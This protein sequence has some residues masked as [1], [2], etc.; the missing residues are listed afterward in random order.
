MP[1]VEPVSLAGRAKTPT[2]SSTT[3][4]ATAPSSWDCS[5]PPQGAGNSDDLRMPVN[6]TQGARDFL[7]D[8]DY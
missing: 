6:A 7:V 5:A 1:S 4:I 2:G 8:D 3:S